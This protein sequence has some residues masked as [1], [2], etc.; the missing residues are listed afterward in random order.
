MKSKIISI[1]Y[2]HNATVGY[3]EDGI[4]KCVLSE[5]RLIRIKN[6]TGFP[7]ATLEF[8]VN[9]FLNGDINKIDKIVLNDET[10][11]GF[12]YIKKTDLNHRHTL[13]I[14]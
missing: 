10:L 11:W 14:I 5:E 3:C 6:A 12:S 1:H 7:Y 8:I 13:I 9:T 4:M 2:G